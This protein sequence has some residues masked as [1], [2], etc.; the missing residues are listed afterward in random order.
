MVEKCPEEHKLDHGASVLNTF[1][2]Q[3]KQHHPMREPTALVMDLGAAKQDR[4]N[5]QKA[6]QISRSN[7]DY[8]YKANSPATEKH[9]KRNGMWAGEANDRRHGGQREPGQQRYL[10]AHSSAHPLP[11]QKQ[12]SNFL[13]VSLQDTGVGQSACKP[14]KFGGIGAAIP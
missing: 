4:A 2:L 14:H 1:F 5:E 6:W 8:R 13:Y 3:Y 7:Q 9:T 10:S 12:G 11:F